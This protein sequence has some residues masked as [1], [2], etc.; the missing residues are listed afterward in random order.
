MLSDPPQMLLRALS[1]LLKLGVGA[2]LLLL[3][4]EAALVGVLTMLAALRDKRREEPWESFPREETPEIELEMSDERLDLYLD[5][6]TLYEAMLKEIEQAKRTIFVETFVW[7]DDEVGRRFVEALARKAR[8]GVEVYAIFDA[9]GSFPA[10][11]GRFP[12]EIHALCFRPLSVFKPASLLSPYNYVRSH[13]KILAVDGRVAFLGEF[14]FGDVY[15][16]N[17]RDT[18]VRVRGD[19]VSEIE[20]AFIGF[21]N[22]Q[23]PE[24][25]P[26]IGLSREERDWNPATVLRVNDPTMGLFPIRAMF[27]GPINRAKRHTYLTSVYFIPSRAIRDAL[28]SAAKRGVDVQVLIPKQSSYALADWLARRHFTELLSAG[29]RIFRYDKHFVIHS[30]TTTV[31]GVWSTVGSANIDS[32]SLFGLH[33]VNL[34]IYSE[35]F[36]G[37]MEDIFERDKTISEEVTLE[38]WENRPLSAKLVEWA[39]TPLRPFA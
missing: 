6:E 2:L 14:N 28:V 16:E 33:E 1:R 13:R 31:D 21:W 17:W 4:A 15:R 25:L 20:E 10:T 36:A 29:V 38:E 19:L 3:A 12:E 5:Y 34:E 35:R 27:F 7:K 30:K 11:S 37:L 24:D 39:L 22:E 18:H 23:R 26:E 8:E 9:L 32:L